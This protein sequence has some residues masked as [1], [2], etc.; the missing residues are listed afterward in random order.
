[1][2]TNHGNDFII[3][4]CPS[5]GLCCCY[6]VVLRHYL[7]CVIVWGLIWYSWPYIYVTGCFLLGENYLNW[8][9]CGIKWHI[10]V[11]LTLLVYRFILDHGWLAYWVDYCLMCL[12]YWLDLKFSFWLV[13]SITF[14]YHI[15]S[16]TDFSDRKRD[17][18]KTPC[19]CMCWTGVMNIGLVLDIIF[20]C[21]GEPPKDPTLGEQ[22]NRFIPRLYDNL[23]HYIIIIIVIFVAFL[24]IVHI[25]YRIS[26][27]ISYLSISFLS[28]TYI[29]YMYIW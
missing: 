24:H 23:M 7:L 13:V 14:S 22:L 5:G 15:H 10:M 16:Y 29:W 4:L 8:E 25:L 21:V 2:G 19:R 3:I 26:F 27:L 12:V 9:L 28:H 6:L 18:F 11:Y 20:V 17:I 1:M